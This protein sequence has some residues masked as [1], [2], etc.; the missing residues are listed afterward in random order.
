M[1][2]VRWKPFSDLMGFS[3][4]VERRMRKMFQEEDSEKPGWA[5]RVDI[6]ETDEDLE[7]VAEIPGM[8]K[9]DIKVSMHEG[10][11]SISG[12][13]KAEE[14]KEGE[15][16]HRIERSFGSFQRSFY[17]PREVDESKISASYDDGVLSVK[18]PKREEARRKEIPIQVK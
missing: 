2:I 7:V 3:D 6:K 15:N 1:A 5:P 8:K 14:E 12:E 17:I 16:W 18:L 10:V 9:E 4:D 13:K 11:L